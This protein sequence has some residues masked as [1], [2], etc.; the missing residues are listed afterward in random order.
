M[1]STTIEHLD[2]ENLL[3]ENKPI[4]LRC[5][6]KECNARIIPYSNKLIHLQ[7]HNAPNAIRAVPDNSPELSDKLIDFYQINDVWDFD[8]IGVSRPSSEI[9]QDPIISH[10]N[11]STIHI[12]RLIVCSECDRGP[13][14]F[15]GIPNRKETDHKNLVYFLSRDSVIYDY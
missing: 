9:S 7:I 1:P 10:D 13:L 8:N 15:A 12:E 11:E 3:S 14:G 4:I 5:P 6:F 2:I